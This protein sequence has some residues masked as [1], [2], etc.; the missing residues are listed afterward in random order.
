MKSSWFEFFIVA[1]MLKNDFQSAEPVLD[2]NQ[3]LQIFS[4][5]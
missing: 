1:A 3:I 2:T 5:T 4:K